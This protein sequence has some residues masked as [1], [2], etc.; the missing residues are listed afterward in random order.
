MIS[1]PFQIGIAVYQLEKLRT[2]EFYYDF[3]DRY[4]DSRDFKLVQMDTD[5]NYIAIFADRLEDIVRPCRLR[6]KSSSGLYRTRGAG[7]CWGCSNMNV[8]AA[9]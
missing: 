7:V 4:F 3:L 1:R 5:S 2:L 8:K 6:D 9:R